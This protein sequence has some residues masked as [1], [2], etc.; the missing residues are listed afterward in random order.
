MFG[1][2][3]R[4]IA[5]IDEKLLEE[6]P[7]DDTVWMAQIGIVLLVSYMFVFSVIYFSLD[8]IVQSGGFVGGWMTVFVS[9]LLTTL[10]VLMD[11]AF[12]MGDWYNGSLHYNWKA[13][14]ASFIVRI[15]KL[16][17]RLAISVFIA[18]T[19]GEALL[20]RFYDAKIKEEIGRYTY[21]QNIQYRKQF[22]SYKQ[23]YELNIHHMEQKVKQLLND[24]TSQN[25]SI[26]AVA[27]T[28]EHNLREQIGALQRDIQE[29]NSDID[30]LKKNQV[31]QEFYQIQHDIGCLDAFISYEKNATRA[32]KITICGETYLSSGI[33]GVGKRVHQLQV[34]RDALKSNLISLEN[35]ALEIE[36]KLKNLTQVRTQKQKQLKVIRNKLNNYIDNRQVQYEKMNQTRKEVLHK[37]LDET[38]A[39]LK[40]LKKNKEHD[41]DVFKH[42]LEKQGLYHQQSDGPMVRYAA[43]QRLYA[44]K[45]YGKERKHFSMMLK[46]VLVLFEI[47]PL[48]MK[49]IFAKRT[50]YGDA[51][52]LR[53]EETLQ[54]LAQKNK[55]IN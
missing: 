7:Y 32:E 9:F 45:E 21:E 10:T 5:G 54:K 2:I 20:L 34:K 35:R 8:Y 19:L 18:Y 36:K 37:E 49:V 27:D 3:F 31:L 13:G 48:L 15:V 24:V 55:S 33:K 23:N 52:R 46:I 40:K 28:K 4:K 30:S 12:I 17:P 44:D 29:I 43:L 41:Y 42:K 14:F 50:P 11:R 38:M 22:E 53:Q 39:V 6:L 51:L 25:M 26:V 47:M 16:L 1:K